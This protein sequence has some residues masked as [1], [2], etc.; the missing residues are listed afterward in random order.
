MGKES[1]GQAPIPFAKV[2]SAGNDAII[3]E[4]ASWRGSSPARKA[5]LVRRIAH[6]SMG[7]GA[8]QVLEVLERNPLRFQV[9]NQ[10]GS[11]A[12]MC[13]NGTRSLCHFAFLRGWIPPASATI[14]VEVSGRPYVVRRRARGFS[15]SLGS[16]VVK[17]PRTLRQR[18]QAIPW[19]SVNV[20]NPHAVIFMTGG[21]GEWRAPSDF[22]FREWGRELE[23]HAAFPQRA[24]IE[25]VRKLRVTGSRAEVLT[26]FWERGAGATLSCGTGA[27]AVAAAVRAQREGVREVLVRMTQ[28]ELRVTFDG[29][30][31]WLSG[32]SV[33]VAEGVWF[34]RRT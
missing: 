30:S 18:G 28:F 22:D 2:H 16:P 8:D 3:L 21:R 20:G 14:S 29:P 7:V 32:P 11:R 10:D 9:W 27:V 34:G 12:E 25:F 13:A 5:E 17:P 24:N 15:V 6:R 31:A 26:E 19:V 4:E 33:L 1:I 23:V